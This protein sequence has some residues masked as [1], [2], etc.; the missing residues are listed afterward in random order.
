M[1]A[2]DSQ[3]ARR[4]ELAPRHVVWASICLAVLVAVAGAV[5]DICL[6]DENVHVRHVRAFTESWERIPY[7]PLSLLP[8]DRD[9][10]PLNNT[11]LWHVGLALIWRVSGESQVLAQFYQAGFYL[12]L[13]L[14]VYFG[15]RA[16]WDATAAG[17]AW[18]LVATSPMACA[19]SILL[20]QDMPGVA[21]SALGLF[22]LWRKKFFLCGIALAAAYLTKMTMLAFV[23]CAAAFALLAS[24][25]DWKQGIRAA[26]LVAAPVVLVLAYDL[27]WQLAVYNAPGYPRIVPP[28][29]HTLSAAGRQA[30]RGLPA[31]YT[32]W[33][34]YPAFYPKSIVTHLGILFVCVL[35]FAL[36]GALDRV[37]L[38]LW[39]CFVVTLLGFFLLFVRVDSTQIR[40]TFPAV[41]ALALLCG[42]GLRRLSLNRWLVAAIAAGCIAQVVATC[43]YIAH[44]RVIPPADGAAFTWIRENVEPTARL[45]FPEELLATQTG[46]HGT[47][48]VLNP[49]FFMSEATEAQQ[50]ELLAFF[51][52]SYIAVPLRRVYDREKEGSHSGG[53]ARDFVEELGSLPWIEKVYE[54]PG[55]LIYRVVPPE[56][57]PPASE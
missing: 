4:F 21:L 40:Y 51:H 28:G 50:R 27:A 34:P 20:Y 15:A 57:E 18:L 42:N 23:P 11:P 45:M 55:F 16:A 43:G 25:E 52:V 36:A 38:T 26:A 53:Y 8:D 2:T 10:L 13:V 6:G 30:F 24:R 1:E 33:R 17:W 14:C 56:E 29:L 9:V 44:K 5:S 7:D 12:L 35:P 39:G 22:L 46:R 37:A 48:G 47:W 32:A 3:Q 19:Y 49:A 54:N 31:D 41:L